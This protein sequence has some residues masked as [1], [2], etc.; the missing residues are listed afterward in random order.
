MKKGI[1]MLFLI[2]SFFSIAQ[3]STHSDYNIPSLRRVQHDTTKIN[4]LLDK[5]GLKYENINPDSSIYFYNLALIIAQNSPE[6]TADNGKLKEKFL[7]YQATAYRYIGIV[8]RTKGLYDK[9]IK[10]YLKSLKISEKLN[11]KDLTCLLYINIGNVL[12]E[13]GSYP[14]AN[15]YYKKALK[16]DLENN[17]KK[18]I[19][20]SYM[21]LSRNYLAL[22]KYN[23]A[24][25]Y[26]LKA[27]KIATD[28]K[29]KEGLPFCYSNI[30]MIQEKQKLYEKALISYDKG[31][32]LAYEVDDLNG[33]AS[34]YSYMSNLHLTIINDVHQNNVDREYHLKKVLEYGEKG[35]QLAL[36][37][38]SFSLQNSIAKCLQQANTK[39]KRYNEA[40][41]YAEIYIA[42]NDSIY[43][44]NKIRVTAE[45]ELKYKS[46]NDQLEI[47]KLAKDSELQQ[48]EIYK[49]KFVLYFLIGVS[50]LILSFLVLLLRLFKDKKIANLAIISQRDEIVK[51]HEKMVYQNQLMLEQSTMITDSIN[52]A[53]RIQQV[54]YPSDDFLSDLLGEHFVLLKPKDIVSGDFFWATRINEFVIVAVADCTGHGVPGA[55]MSMLGISNLNEIV[56]QK[57][58]SNAAQ[59]LELLRALIIESL[60]QKGGTEEQKDGLDIALCVI[61]VHTLELQFS[62][63]YLPCII[64][65]NNTH[66]LIKLNG[67]NMPIGIHPEMKKFDNQIIQ[68]EKGDIIYLMSDGFQDQFGGPNNRKFLPKNVMKTF[69]KIKDLSMSEQ[70]QI[71]NETIEDWKNNY[72]IKYEQT[73]DIT[74]LGFKVEF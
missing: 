35:Y 5:I 68:L 33:V 16:I 62:G 36:T 34:I 44:R 20:E 42:T 54:I 70:K 55:L 64:I 31:L 27:L 8:Y 13:Q 49:Q 26:S 59:V 4:I 66:E 57:A 38:K 1:V 30:G 10:N 19:S 67:N 7:I 22:K 37:L 11:D 52:Y 53:K 51:Q 12:Y 24:M 14:K 46:K 61:N 74:I 50:V 47:E 58:I 21:C 18:G 43:Q 69:S 3:Y 32:Q 29:Y 48:S 2:V 39:L 40:L 73:D 15:W 71:L 60:N 65:K 56:R 25:S 28:I 9:A 41:K 63:A 17:N 23:T 72:G 6:A 45:L